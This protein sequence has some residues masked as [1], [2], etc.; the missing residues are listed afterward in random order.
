MYVLENTDLVH[1][2]CFI[3]SFI[4]CLL[5]NFIGFLKSTVSS[6][7]EDAERQDLSCTVSGDIN[8]HT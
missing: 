4:L 1:E 5:F 2:V 6:A 7:G 8:I 3:Y